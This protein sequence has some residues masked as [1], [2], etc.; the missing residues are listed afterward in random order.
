MTGVTHSP[1]RPAGAYTGYETRISFVVT[2][3]DANAMRLIF[4]AWRKLPDGTKLWAKQFGFKAW[5]IWIE[6]EEVLTS[7]HETN[8][9]APTGSGR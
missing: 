8:T 4:R 7:D 5:P 2:D 1:V 9:A 6:D 3:T